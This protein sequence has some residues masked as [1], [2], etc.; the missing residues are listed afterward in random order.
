MGAAT[1][2]IP[3]HEVY[4]ALQQGVAGAIY[5][6]LNTFVS[7]K[8]YEVAPKVVRWP[9]SSVYIWVANKAFW[10]K[11]S[12]ADRTLIRRLAGEATTEYNRMIWG[13]YDE[14]VKTV[15]A[16]PKGEFYEFTPA[17]VELFRTRL[18]GLLDGW[19]TEFRTV[20]SADAASGS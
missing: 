10:D 18:R 15:R 1:I 2:N 6:T 9:G 5:T 3:I 7:G 12:E 4:T 17:D 19:H 11:L 13:N 8:T 16:A 20:L 14:L